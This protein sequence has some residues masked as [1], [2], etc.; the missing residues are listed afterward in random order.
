MESEDD[1]PTPK[2]FTGRVKFY[3]RTRMYGFITCDVLSDE[4]KD[5]RDIFV[6]S[7]A[8][9]P[10]KKHNCKPY[11]VDGEY[12]EFN[13]KKSRKGDIAVSVRGIGNGPLM[14]DSGFWNRQKNRSQHRFSSNDTTNQ[15]NFVVEGEE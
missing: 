2:L 14:M 10:Y 8:V 6:H 12:V 7:S 13:I 4:R 1:T 5:Q 9:E 11:L 3:S 15:D